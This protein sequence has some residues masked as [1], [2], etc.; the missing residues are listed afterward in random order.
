M[1]YLG[2]PCCL[3]QYNSN[4]ELVLKWS[5]PIDTAGSIALNYS[6]EVA[7]R[8]M[9][10][11]IIVNTTN[12]TFAVPIID[13]CSNYSWSVTA[14][15]AGRRSLPVNNTINEEINIFEG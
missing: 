4:N 9:L 14:I 1:S 2:P 3:T 5:T 15:T 6:Y 7:L 11:T 8:T 10:N 12:N 13:L